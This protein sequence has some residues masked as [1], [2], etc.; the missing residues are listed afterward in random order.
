MRIIFI[1]TLLF[2]APPSLAG[3][4]DICKIDYLIPNNCSPGDNVRIKAEYN[5]LP[6]L[7]FD[8][9]SFQNE[10]VFLSNINTVLCIKK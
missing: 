6:E 7:I 3:V 10:I 9:C 1:F 5:N 4:E 8:N 2:Y